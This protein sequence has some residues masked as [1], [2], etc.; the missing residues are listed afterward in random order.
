MEAVDVAKVIVVDDHA[1]LLESLT[2][3][4]GRDPSIELV[5]ALSSGGELEATIEG[6]VE[7]DVVV[8]DLELGDVLATEIVPMVQRELGAPI[9][10]ISGA[11]DRRGVTAAIESGCAGFLSKGLPLSSLVGAIRTIADGGSVYPASLLSEVI[12]LGATPPV[13]LTEKEMEVLRLLAAGEP[14][15]QIARQLYVSIHTTRNHIRSILAKL[16]ARSQLEAVVLAVRS[17]L[18]RIETE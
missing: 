6:G 5:A 2:A 12:G 4:L 18:I 7:A 14:A 17:G 15:A 11:G 16:N 13:Q 10:L 1:M 9:L 8:L 3:A